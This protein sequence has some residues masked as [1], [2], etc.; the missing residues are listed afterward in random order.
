MAAP[1]LSVQQ[2]ASI[3]T[4][5]NTPPWHLAIQPGEESAAPVHLGDLIT[6]MSAQEVV[7][8]TQLR[9]PD[10][11]SLSSGPQS[12]EQQEF[13][14]SRTNLTADDITALSESLAQQGLTLVYI[15]PDFRIVGI[16]GTM[17]AFGRTWPLLGSHR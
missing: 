5:Q 4:G 2:F 13:L 15:S 11:F 6:Q 3:V 1:Q 16:K 9:N 10:I 12:L 17:G 8:F 14:F 7:V